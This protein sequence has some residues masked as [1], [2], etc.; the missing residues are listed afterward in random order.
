MSDI[1]PLAIVREHGA[2]E[3][4]GS[5]HSATK[6]LE[7]TQLGFP[8]LGVGQ[9]VIESAIPWIFS[10][11]APAG[12]LGAGFARRFPELRLPD[13]HWSD[14]HVLIAISRRGED[15][16]GNLLVGAESRRRFEDSFAPEI[17]SGA[18]KRDDYARVIEEL[19][20]PGNFGK[21]SSLGG[22]RPKVVLH[23]VGT[24]T[25]RDMLLKFTPPLSTA[26]GTRWKNLLLVETLAA[27][28]LAADGIL[29]SGASPGTFEFIRGS[30]RAG[31]LM[32]RFDR[33]SGVGRR[34]AATLYYLAMARDE[35]ELEAPAV[36]ASLARDGLV[37]EADAKTVARVHSFSAA[38]GNTNAHLGNYGL[39]F[40]EKGAAQLSPIY[41]VTAMVFAPR[42]DELPDA[43]IKPRVGSIAS[44]LA[45][46]VQTLVD[47]ARDEGRLDA[48]FRDQWFRYMGV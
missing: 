11:M 36:F 14:E 40:D 16:S 17:M 45:P 25:P 13:Q 31:I 37:S 43:R 1:T 4:L 34:G 44:D 33:T 9:H 6:T 5:W 24:Q 30:D 19:L 32:P 21:D 22:A 35:F 38:I 48:D 41:D 28:A 3:D 20:A 27:Q 47:L 26:L 10:D 7:L 39:R 42:A 2:V 46:L 8:F 12:F 23:S 29:T 18:R 15:L